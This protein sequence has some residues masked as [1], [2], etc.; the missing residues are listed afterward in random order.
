MQ[1]AHRLAAT[2]RGNDRGRDHNEVQ[3][4]HKT[5]DENRHAEPMT[6]AEQNERRGERRYDRDIAED[7][8]EQVSGSRAGA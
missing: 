6:D 2:S 4:E 7:V 5:C 3:D 1:T 8:R